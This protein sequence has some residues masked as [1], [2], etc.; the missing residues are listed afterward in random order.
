ME[1]YTM[2]LK[3]LCEEE[4]I[5][6]QPD[7]TLNRLAKRLGTNRTYLSETLHKNLRTSFCSFINS[8][9]AAYAASLLK[10]PGRTVKEIRYLSGFSSY[11]GF[12]R[13]F[14]KVY[15]CTP[16]EYQK[17]HCPVC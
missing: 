15:G 4:L 8:Q 3:R 17:R 2:Q 11:N 10:H 13:A 1:D 7:I 5:Y 16:G 9:R 12:R 14:F 6:L